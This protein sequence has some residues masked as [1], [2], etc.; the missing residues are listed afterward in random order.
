MVTDS[1]TT[2]LRAAV[3][4]DT[5]TFD[6]LGGSS[7]QDYGPEFAAL[8]AAAFICATRRRFAAGWSKSD[9][10]RFVGRLR[11]RNHGECSD[12]SADAAEK[13]IISA[14]SGEPMHGEHEAAD[15]GYA[16]AAILT[17]LAADLDTCELD[18]LLDEARRMADQWLSK[19]RRQLA[20]FRAGISP[21]T[22][23]RRACVSVILVGEE[24]DADTKR[25]G[26]R[27]HDGQ[28]RIS[29]LATLQPRK[30]TPR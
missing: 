12:V 8:S 18:A 25:H 14:L 29:L 19:P 9:V 11:A 24:R 15:Q 10:I 13:M 20:A 4:G 17:G 21:A 27:T 1:Q 23:T 3:T 6:L 30:S 2:A 16:Q 22:A 7:G 26:Y 28:A 5:A